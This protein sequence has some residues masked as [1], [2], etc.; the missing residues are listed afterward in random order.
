M[1]RNDKWNGTPRL[2][3][4]ERK[5]IARDQRA[6]AAEGRR[7]QQLA[8]IYSRLKDFGAKWPGE[9]RTLEL[10]NDPELSETNIVDLLVMEQLGDQVKGLTR[11][12]VGKIDPK[13]EF[14][15]HNRGVTLV[16]DGQLLAVV[17]PTHASIRR[18]GGTDRLPGDFTEPGSLWVTFASRLKKRLLPSSP[19]E[20]SQVSSPQDHS[21]GWMLVADRGILRESGH[22]ED[23]LESSR[24]IRNDR[25]YALACPATLE[26]GATTVRLDPVETFGNAPVVPFE[27]GRFDRQYRGVIYLRAPEIPLAIGV[28]DEY[29]DE[30]AVVW[31]YALKAFADLTCLPKPSS[32]NSG[33]VSHPSRSSRGTSG[34]SSTSRRRQA[35]ASNSRI[36][37]SDTP[38]RPDSSTASLLSSFVV[39]HIRNLPEGH[40]PS[41]DAIAEAGDLGIELGPEQTWV[42]PHTKGMPEFA[43]MTFTWYPDVQID[44]RD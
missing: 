38:L 13:I 19:A 35:G 9:E 16:Y 40:S 5:A 44:R 20:F 30:L 18:D 7:K 33:A 12:Y 27:V 10:V 22:L 6:K 28:E 3:S 36:D 2:S 23:A 1:K 42:K 4:T 41:P 32:T 34:A 17:T 11:Q 31:T 21:R 37:F 43:R 29:A 26:S 24:R 8:A 15:D 14:R 25:R 39:G